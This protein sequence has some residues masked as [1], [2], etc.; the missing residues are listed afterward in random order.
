MTTFLSTLAT[1]TVFAAFIGLGAGETIKSLDRA[2]RDQ[3]ANRAWPAHQHQ[4]H[5]EFCKTYLQ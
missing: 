1:A 5:V 4:A 3:C 2:T